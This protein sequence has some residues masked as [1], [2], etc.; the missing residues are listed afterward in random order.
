MYLEVPEP[1][2]ARREAEIARREAEIAHREAEIAHREAEIAR[3]EAE[4][5]S[6]ISTISHELRT[7]LN[8]VLGMAE[9][10]KDTALDNEQTEYLD[11]LLDSGGA[12]LGVINDIL[13]DSRLEATAV[14][15]EPLT[16]NPRTAVEGV[17]RT[18]SPRAAARGITLRESVAAEVPLR[19]VGDA[20]R[21]EQILAKLADNAL[22]FTESGWITVSLDA[23]SGPAGKVELRFAVEDTGI[24]VAS[25]AHERILEPFTQVDG[26]TTRR[27]GGTGLGLSICRRL[28][29]LMGGTLGVSARPGGGSTFWFNL[30][31]PSPSLTARPTTPRPA[32]L[33]RPK[34]AD[35]A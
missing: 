11:T 13:D 20:G 6:T 17:V 22:K 19:L 34:E 25:D 29:D 32:A 1:D 30:L 9:L 21:I 14:A 23:A 16:F 7:P 12:L 2:I 26:S 24:G 10:L 3:R 18:L 8:G 28:V 4:F 15:L 5:I 31:L 33:P 35:A 27:Y